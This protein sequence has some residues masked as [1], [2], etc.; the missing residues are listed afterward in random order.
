MKIN[1]V[2]NSNNFMI[3][4]DELSNFAYD[5]IGGELEAILDNTG[6]KEII[7][8]LENITTEQQKPINFMVSK[9]IFTLD[10]NNK[11]YPNK[12]LTRY[13]FSEA[14]VKIFFVLDRSLQTYFTDLTK[15]NYYYPYV[16]SGEKANVIK[17]YE[18]NTFRGDIY[19]PTEQVVA[20]CARTLAEKKCISVRNC[21]WKQ[22]IT[23]T[24][25]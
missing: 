1:E 24:I 7:N 18:D 5:Y 6:N 3:K 25:C 20:L 8:G 19:I 12:E 2:T 22:I 10:E 21:N 14:L 17:G 9:G 4:V 15:E 23:K 11:F 13:V 16:V